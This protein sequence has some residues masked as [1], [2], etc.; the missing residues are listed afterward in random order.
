MNRWRYGK[1]YSHEASFDRLSNYINL[2]WYTID[3]K[4]VIKLRIVQ[5]CAGHVFKVTWTAY[6]AEGKIRALDANAI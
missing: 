5:D 4:S 3:N 2:T 6:T 1:D